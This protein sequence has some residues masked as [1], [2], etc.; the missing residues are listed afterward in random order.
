MIRQ[1]ACGMHNLPVFGRS[2]W[3]NGFRAAAGPGSRSGPPRSMSRPGSPGVGDRIRASPTS[4]FDALGFW[5]VSP[6]VHAGGP[7]VDRTT[8]YGTSRDDD[9]LQVVW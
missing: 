9:A 8:R 7:Q 6:V 1:T 2:L 3:L 5:R 4:D